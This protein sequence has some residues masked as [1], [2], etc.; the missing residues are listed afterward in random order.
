MKRKFLSVVILPVLILLLAS[1]GGGGI[2]NPPVE[3]KYAVI[4]AGYEGIFIVDISD[5]ENPV[6]VGSL[7]IGQSVSKVQVVGNYAYLASV[8]KG[9]V[10]VDLSD[11][12]DP[13]EVGSVNTMLAVGVFV[14]GNYAYVANS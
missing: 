12:S 8:G 4:A 14:S 11:P 7:S 3:H 5:P 1:C 10:V 13:K 6:Q 9:L 2:G